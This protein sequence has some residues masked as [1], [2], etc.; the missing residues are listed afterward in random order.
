MGKQN[1]KALAKELGISRSSLYYKPKQPVK[2]WNLKIE[3]EKIL[4]K[5]P[6]YGHKRLA[7]ELKVNRKRTLRVMR[8]FGIKPYR[9]RGR[10]FRKA[11]LST[12]QANCKNLLLETFPSSPNEVW[13]SDF[14]Y[15]SFKGKTLY[16][17]TVMD[18]YTRKTVGFAV[19][20]THS[21]QLIINALF[22]AIHKHPPPKIFHSDQG[23]EYASKDFGNILDELG[24]KQSMSKKASPWENGYQESFYSHF[25]VDLGDPNRFSCLG[26]LVYQI[27]RTIYIYNNFRIHTSLKTSPHTF[28]LIHQ[29]SSNLV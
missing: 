10:K 29:L 6:S 14:T 25:K 18:L 21:T 2:D 19:L 13:V 3:I 12:E 27:Y 15:L 17:A 11:K 20:D 23:S 9:R 16:L 26:E 24:I 28:A 8:M 7:L 4:R 22:S 5:F 1:K